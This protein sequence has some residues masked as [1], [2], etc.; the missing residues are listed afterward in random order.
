MK[1]GQTMQVYR[2]GGAVRDKYL[3]LEVSDQDWVVV[4][5]TPEQMQALGYRPVGR[6]FPVFLHPVTG[7]EYA[8]ARTER[9]Q[10]RGYKGFVIHAAPDV[11]LEAD[12]QRRDLTINAMAEDDR[13]QL[14]DP[15]G[16]LQ[17]LQQRLL[18]AVSPAFAE[19]PLRVLR[20][21]R[22]AARFAHL[23]FQV[24]AGTLFLMQQLVDA[25]ELGFLTP[26]RCQQ[27]LAKALQTQTPSVFFQLLQQLGALPLLWPALSAHWSSHPEIATLL[28]GLP[29]PDFSVAQRFAV[30]GYQAGAD[31][32]RLFEGLVSL[33]GEWLRQ[34]KALLVLQG[35]PGLQADQAAAVMDLFDAVDAWRHPDLLTSSLQLLEALGE[36]RQRQALL[37]WL[38]ELQA[39]SAA[40]LVAAGLRGPAVGQA[41][42]ERRLALLESLIA[43]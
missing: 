28:N 19:D 24:E 26:E 41:L 14:I 27:E 4:G 36:T 31:F 11:T 37:D 30:L 7:E 10:G 25:G 12:L 35:H 2:V 38:T 18:R 6:D 16:G 21:A 32:Y 3:G 13:G 40:P 29:F 17:D 43:G 34:L 8:L 33:P 22:F 20:T 1:R 15:W 23:G 9:K 39:I 5:A 42:R